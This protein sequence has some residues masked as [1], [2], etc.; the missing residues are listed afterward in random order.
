MQHAPHHHPPHIFLDETIYFITCRTIGAKDYFNTDSFKELF[1]N[2]LKNGV[3]KFNIPIYAWVTLSN[4][5]HLLLK[6]ID[7]KTLSPLMQAINGAS[8]F[9]LN[10]IEGQR[11]RKVWYQYWD[12]CIRDED[13]FFKHFNYI[14]H[15]PVKHGFIK[16]TQG[17]G[18]Y[19]FSSYCSWLKSHGEEFLINNFRDYPIVDFSVAGEVET[20]PEETRL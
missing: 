5:Y 9:E 11:G 8:S 18:D 1:V 19:K 20:R 6:I 4:H 17:L 15:N 12:R 14:H 10:R 7:K 16:T 3:E 2:Y 13:D